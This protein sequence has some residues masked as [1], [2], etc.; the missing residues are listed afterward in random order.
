MV[1]FFFSNRNSKQTLE[2]HFRVGDIVRIR[3]WGAAYSDWNYGNR[4]FTNGTESPFYNKHWDKRNSKLLF[5]IK[6]MAFHMYDRDGVICYVEDREKKGV[7]INASALE[8]VRQFPLRKD[9]R[10]VVELEKMK[11]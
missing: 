11:F 8:V 4:F 6:K 5:K 7:I 1:T 2:Y 9:E 10:Q 3:H